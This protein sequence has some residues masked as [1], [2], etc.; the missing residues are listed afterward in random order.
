MLKNYKLK[1]GRYLEIDETSNGYQYSLYENCKT[2][3]DGGIIETQETSEEKIL[4][5]VLKIY[6]ISSI[7]GIDELHEDIKEVNGIEKIIND[8]TRRKIINLFDK[9]KDIEAL[10]K[11]YEYIFTHFIFSRNFIRV[12]RKI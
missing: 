4:T 9:N 11:L 7:I 8:K 5:E 6:D 12:D 3:L 1:D 10:E 2:L